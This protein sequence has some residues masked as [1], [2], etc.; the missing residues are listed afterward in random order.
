MRTTRAMR[1]LGD[2]LLA[3]AHL[4]P[5][6]GAA[7]IIGSLCAAYGRV[8][9]GRRV[10]FRFAPFPP[11]TASGLWLGMEDRDLL[12][13]EERTRPAHQLVIASHELWHVDEGTCGRHGAGMAVA[14]RLTGPRGSLSD[15]LSTDRGLGSVVRQAAARADRED[16]AEIR[17]ETFGLHLGK[18]LQ[19][20]LPPPREEQVPE[21]VERIKSSFGW[22][23]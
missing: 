9:G 5:P 11:D 13:I 15:L 7:E 18:I 4:T 8:R 14:A 12:V 21:A 22:G 17:A 10:E 1:K 2:D 19:A 3:A 20:F 16:P 6:A 23:R